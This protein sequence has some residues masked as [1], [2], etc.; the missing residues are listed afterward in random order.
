MAKSE[1][2]TSYFLV[3]P[4]QAGTTI[5]AKEN[6]EMLGDY[7]DFMKKMGE[8]LYISVLIV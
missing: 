4:A 3:V 8:L 6:I 5:D 2:K 7:D 1:T